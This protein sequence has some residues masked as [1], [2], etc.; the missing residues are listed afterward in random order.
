MNPHHEAWPRLIALARRARDERDAAAPYGFATRVAALGLAV[1]TLPSP[2]L[3][4]EK[5]AL[6]GLFAAGALSV[7][8]VAYGFTSASSEAE[9]DVLAADIVSEVLAES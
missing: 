8:A 1:R 3:L 6:R 5:F 9:F 2:R 4:L 7:A